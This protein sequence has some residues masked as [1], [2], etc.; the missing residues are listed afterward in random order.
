MDDVPWGSKP[1]PRSLQSIRSTFSHDSLNFG[2]KPSSCQNPLTAMSLTIHHV[3]YSP[4]DQ[5]VWLCE[6]L[7]ISYTLKR[8]ARFYRL[9]GG[10]KTLVPLPPSAS[11]DPH[12]TLHDIFPSGQLPTFEEAAIRVDDIVQERGGGRLT[13]PSSHPEHADFRAWVN[14]VETQLRDRAAGPEYEGPFSKV[15]RLLDQRVKEKA[16]LAGNEFTAAD[17]KLVH[18]LTTERLCRTRGF[19]LAGYHGILAY[20]GRVTAREAYRRAMASCEPQL[21]V[22]TVIGAEVEAV[23]DVNS[24]ALEPSRLDI[25]TY[26]DRFLVFSNF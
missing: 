15:L 12:P 9:V 1:L 5:L 16:W 7:S 25:E 22:K 3:T 14:F 21:D 4:S 18:S 24:L 20:L 26:I 10:H 23:M 17:I 13:L 2:S 8:Y 6:E 11:G 19:S